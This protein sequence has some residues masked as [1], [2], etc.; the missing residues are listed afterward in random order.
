MRPLAIIALLVALAGAKPGPDTA[1]TLKPVEPMFRV[2]VV[3]RP[4]CPPS[5]DLELTADMPDP[6]WSLN[7]D[8]V[9]DPDET[10][11]RVVEI[12]ATRGD[13][14]FPQV[15]TART[16]KVPLGILRKG[17]YLIDV[18]VRQ[19]AAKY[20]RVQAIVLRGAGAEAP[21]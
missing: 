2:R 7:V 5:F 18:Q 14:M 10:L 15:V 8:R 17:V 6:G 16:A 11:R 20:E 21:R 1:L 3:E 12:T 19:G 4:S 13:G 9:A